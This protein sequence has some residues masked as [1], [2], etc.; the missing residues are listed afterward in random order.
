MR[1]AGAAYVLGATLLA[2]LCIALVSL[3]S[4]PVGAQ[5]ATT[6]PEFESIAISEQAS[7]R[8]LSS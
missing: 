3:V 4:D 5:E 1:R 2:L 6:A 7:A 8:F